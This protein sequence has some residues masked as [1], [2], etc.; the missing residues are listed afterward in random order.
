[1]TTEVRKRLDDII[2]LRFLF[3]FLLKWSWLVIPLAIG[4]VYLGY[5]DLQNFQPRY[6]AR[7]I[8]APSGGGGR[9]DQIGQVSAVLSGL[10][11]NLDSGGGS[12]KFDRLSVVLSSISLAERLQTRYQLLQ[13]VFS[14]SCESDPISLDTELA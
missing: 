8:V 13:T 12:S 11:L 10:G 7:M 14:G 6:V 4:G 1:M 2:D 9:P 3:L 5:R